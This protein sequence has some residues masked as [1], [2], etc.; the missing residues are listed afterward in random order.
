[1]I[2][3]LGRFGLTF[4]PKEEGLLLAGHALGLLGTA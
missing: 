1:M 4:Q 2:G 3:S